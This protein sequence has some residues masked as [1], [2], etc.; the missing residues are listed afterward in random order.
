MDIQKTSVN[1]LLRKIRTY[2]DTQP[3]TAKKGKRFVE[4][5]QALARLEKIFAVKAGE[6][7]LVAC[8][9]KGRVIDG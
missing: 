1:L 2:L 8:K 7:E 5:Q 4:A 3:E 6:I 9:S